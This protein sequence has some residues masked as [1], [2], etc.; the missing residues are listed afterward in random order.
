M[1]K[2]GWT[3]WA[4]GRLGNPRLLSRTWS[5]RVG[6][7]R[8]GAEPAAAIDR[9]ELTNEQLRLIGDG[10]Y[11]KVYKRKGENGKELTVER[12]D[13]T[14]FKAQ[15]DYGK[16]LETELRN[17][18]L[19]EHPNLL[20]FFHMD[21]LV[22]PW[23]Y[24]PR[25]LRY[26]YLENGTNLQRYLS[27]NPQEL[28]WQTC[29]GI[30][31]GICDGLAY[32]HTGQEE[33]IYHLDISPRCIMLDKSMTPKLQYV[34]LSKFLYPAITW[35]KD[36]RP[37]HGTPGY[38]PPEY[39][40]ANTVSEKFDVFSFGVVMIN[41]LTGVLK[42]YEQ[43]CKMP[44]EKIIDLAQKNWRKILEDKRSGV[45]QLELYCQQV[46]KC[47]KIALSCLERDMDERPNV[48]EIIKRLN[49][50]DDP[51]SKIGSV[52]AASELRVGSAA[53]QRGATVLVSAAAVAR[54]GGHHMLE[55][56]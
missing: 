6:S 8:G 40:L 19:L 44:P 37:D 9:D 34:S 32:L 13:K 49:E 50:P 27:D 21:R 4:V 35:K 25:E 26:E 42:G 46:T 43:I 54:L 52:T 10:K 38:R 20:R 3:Q 11:G 31:K 33:P 48:R 16:K 41:I 18:M 2:A 45:S 56:R 47:T 24:D 36:R 55:R 12:V 29:Y 7:I 22:T 51:Q 23:W 17:L 14:S 39:L 30:I 15:L 53:W 5:P 28:D 1:G